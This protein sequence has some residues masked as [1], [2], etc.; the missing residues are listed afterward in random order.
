MCAGTRTRSITT[1]DVGQ[2][3]RA[4]TR[5]RTHAYTC[6]HAHRRR[7]SSCAL[8]PSTHAVEAPRHAHPS[9]R[10][11]VVAVLALGHR[12]AYGRRSPRLAR[13]REVV[14]RGL[15][16]RIERPHRAGGQHALAH[17]RACPRTPSVSAAHTVHRM[18]AACACRGWSSGLR[19][20]AGDCCSVRM[21]RGHAL[22]VL[23][24]PVVPFERLRA[25]EGERSLLE[26]LLIERAALLAQAAWRAHTGR[27]RLRGTALS[28]CRGGRTGIGS[29]RHGWPGCT[30][31]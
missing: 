14:G 31:R 29:H 16:Q 18:R 15:R 1:T 27:S 23:S 25:L 22:D 19:R 9:A 7:L 10:P 12:C 24:V 28:S 11:R 17:V 6:T 3:C 21:E 13:W 30:T 2:F 20:S 26:A 8:R 4:H 5:T